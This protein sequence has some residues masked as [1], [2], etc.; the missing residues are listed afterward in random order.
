MA[1]GEGLAMSEQLIANGRIATLRR[2]RKFYKCERCECLIEPGEFYYSV[3]VA[4]SGVTGMIDAERAHL[5]CFS[6]EE[7]P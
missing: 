1:R 6:I 3:V 4:G 7:R 2:A 5:A